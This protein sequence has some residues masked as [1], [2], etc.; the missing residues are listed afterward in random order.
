MQ[1]WIVNLHQ[2]ENRLARI[3]LLHLIVSFPVSEEEAHSGPSSFRRSTSLMKVISL[4][5]LLRLRNEETNLLSQ[6]LYPWSGK[7]K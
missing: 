5:L 4:R 6:G 2:E 1:H 3:V 7:G